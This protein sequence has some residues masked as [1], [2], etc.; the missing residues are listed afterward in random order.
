MRGNGRRAK[1]HIF[2]A[3]FL[4]CGGVDIAHAGVRHDLH[5]TRVHLPPLIE[6]DQIVVRATLIGGA[7]PPVG[8]KQPLGAVIVP[9]DDAK[10]ALRASRETGWRVGIAVD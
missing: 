5:I 3:V 10:L 8:R 4:N 6:H 9:V 2:F 1:S 7:A